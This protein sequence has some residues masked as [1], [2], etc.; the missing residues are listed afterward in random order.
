LLE[1]LE[2]EFDAHDED[3]AGPKHNHKR[4]RDQFHDSYENTHSDHSYRH[5]DDSY[6]PQDPYGPDHDEQYAYKP[7]GKSSFRYQDKSD[8]ACVQETARSAC[9]TDSNN[10]IKYM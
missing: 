9:Q 2:Q 8:D 4:G 10:G 5:D 3:Y 1:D 6:G 7:R